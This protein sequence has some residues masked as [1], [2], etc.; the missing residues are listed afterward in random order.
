MEIINQID[1]NALELWILCLA[2]SLRMANDAFNK[3]SFSALM[4]CSSACCLIVALIGFCN[5]FF[6]NSGLK[7]FFAAIFVNLGC[8]EL[9]EHRRRKIRELEEIKNNYF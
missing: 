4:Y 9:I 8:C 1:I 2:S 6:F 7:P 5:I 3:S